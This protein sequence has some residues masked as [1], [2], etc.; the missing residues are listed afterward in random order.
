MTTPSDLIEEVVR[1]L[2]P[3]AF[4]SWQETFKVVISDGGSDRQARIIAD[5]SMAGTTIAEARERAR[6]AAAVIIEACAKVA[7]D[8]A[9]HGDGELWI[10][11]KIAE[12][13]R[14]LAHAKPEEA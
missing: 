3:A 1:A 6:I 2:E 12:G 5:N 9:I 13:I 8:E 14:A 4:R 7:E 11:N 10:D